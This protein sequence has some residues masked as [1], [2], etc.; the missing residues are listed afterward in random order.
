M[1][2]INRERN[3]EGLKLFLNKWINFFGS[4]TIII[5]IFDENK[6]GEHFAHLKKGG[7]YFLQKRDEDVFLLKYFSVLVTR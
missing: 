7:K 6:E 3:Y 1:S 4:G 2:Q 5:K